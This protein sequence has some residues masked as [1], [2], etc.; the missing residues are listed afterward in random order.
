MKQSRGL[1]EPIAYHEAGHAVAAY[2]LHIKIRKLSI[3]PD[4]DSHG[5]MIQRDPFAGINIEWDETP[6]AHL[7]TQQAIVVYL[8]GPVAQKRFRA[9]SYRRLHGSS[10]HAHAVDLA[11]RACGSEQSATAFLKWLH[12]EASDMMALHWPMVEAVARELLVKNEIIGRAI[13][14]LL[15]RVSRSAK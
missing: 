14:E 1:R 11:L 7:R 12:I 4:H 15:A 6:R 9:R 3:I 2:H 10:D 5:R 8:A 13:P